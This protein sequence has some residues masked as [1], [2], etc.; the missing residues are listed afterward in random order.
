MYCFGNYELKQINIMTKL[1]E[2]QGINYNGIHWL[3]PL[4]YKCDERF[5]IPLGYPLY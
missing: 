4:L 1:S 3:N 2:R 5:I